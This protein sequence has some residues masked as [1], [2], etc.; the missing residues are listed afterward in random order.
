VV[1]AVGFNPRFAVPPFCRSSRSDG[2][3]RR[4]FQKRDN[5]R[6]ERFASR[7]NRLLARVSRIGPFT[8]RLVWAIRL[9]A[10]R[11]GRCV[12]RAQARCHCAR[13][14]GRPT[15]V[16]AAFQ[17]RELAP[18]MGPLLRVREMG[19]VD[20]KPARPHVTRADLGANQLLHPFIAI[21]QSIFREG[22]QGAS[23]FRLPGLE[24]LLVHTIGRWQV[25]LL[26]FAASLVSGLVSG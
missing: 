9:L 16:P 8:T 19:W 23:R 7:R 4:G 13:R 3:Q 26:F 11:V 10:P 6:M 2:G 18:K 20:G 17:S 5:V 15:Q 12:L 14:W 24:S 22:Q 1:V 21:R 25:I